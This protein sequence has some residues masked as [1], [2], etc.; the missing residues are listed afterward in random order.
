MSMYS[1][2]RARHSSDGQLASSMAAINCAVALPFTPHTPQLSAVAA[3]AQGPEHHQPSPFRTAIP[4]EPC[5]LLAV[6]NDGVLVLYPSHVG[7]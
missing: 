1:D 5:W 7:K 3:P 2:A 4:H 6:F